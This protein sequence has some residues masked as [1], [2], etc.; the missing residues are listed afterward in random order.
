MLCFCFVCRLII[1]FGMINLLLGSVLGWYGL[2][3]V[4]DS[5]SEL[6]LRPKPHLITD[7]LWMWADV[8]TFTRCIDRVY[9]CDTVMSLVG[10]IWH[11]VE[12]PITS[13]FK[14]QPVQIL[15][16]YIA[17]AHHAAS[18]IVYTGSRAHKNKEG[19][20]ALKSCVCM[21][22]SLPGDD[23]TEYS[24]TLSGTALIW[25]WEWC[26]EVN[27]TAQILAFIIASNKI[28]QLLKQTGI[29]SSACMRHMENFTQQWKLIKI[30]LF[31]KKIL[32][33]A[34]TILEW[35]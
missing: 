4:S 1:V 5:V 13:Q 33:A 35:N 21:L 24:T 18:E 3:L 22:T 25:E 32:S 2:N 7:S 11:L 30:N 17:C 28:M 14:S 12:H 16:Y 29:A 19:G 10:W 23:E 26:R 20:H 31:C 15:S 34:L 8:S 6:G 9:H 27:Y